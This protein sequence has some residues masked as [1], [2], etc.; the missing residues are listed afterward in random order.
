[1]L[2]RHF[3][4]L[5]LALPPSTV[6]AESERPRLFLHS[7]RVEAL[8][9]AITSTHAALWRSARRKAD[10][11]V[12][13]SPPKHQ[14]QVGPND[15]QLWQ[16]E[17]ANK[18]P[19]LA[20]VFLLTGDERYLTATVEWSMASCGY[21][22]WGTGSEDGVGLAA[23]HQ[24][25]SLALV[26]DWLGDFERLVEEH[27]GL[28]PVPRL[29]AERLEGGRHGGGYRRQQ[30]RG[31]VRCRPHSVP[32]RGAESGPPRPVAGWR[33]QAG[34]RHQ[35]CSRMAG[36]PLVRPFRRQPAKWTAATGTASRCPCIRCE[37]RR[38]VPP[39]RMWLRFPGLRPAPIPSD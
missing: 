32:A 20:L 4:A 16:R 9:A 3:T 2:R 12:A 10:S 5:L 39:G 29:A 36:S 11:I 19:L 1:M 17:V 15:E 14:E 38:P 27:S 13:K 22:H 37:W 23:G 30:A 34:R 8:Q 28:P 26:Y 35:L 25:F 24:L 6:H 21:P 18:I 7:T 33:D 31:R